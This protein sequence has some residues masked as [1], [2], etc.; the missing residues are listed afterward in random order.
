MKRNYFVLTLVVYI[1][2]L[3]FAFQHDATP[4]P[5]PK[6]SAKG[7]VQTFSGEISD[8]Q[9]S[10]AGSHDMVMKKASVNSAANCTKGCA[11]THGYVLYD[12]ASK[13]V[14]KLDDQTRPKKFA[15][16]SVKVTGNLNHD[17]IHMVR[18]EAAK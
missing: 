11:R 5:A 4:A 10:K 1:G 3:A 7:P 9:C 18:I 13:K 12:R 2:V 17:T 15:A 6:A 16:K 8:G 14:Y